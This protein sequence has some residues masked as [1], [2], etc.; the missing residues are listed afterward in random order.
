MKTDARVERNRAA[1]LQGAQEVLKEEGWEALT[2]ERVA[3]RSGVGRSTVYRHWPDRTALLMDA[4]DAIGAAMHQ[5]ATGDL[6]T[7]LVGELERFRTMISQPAEGR[8]LATLAYHWCTDADVGRFKERL[9]ARHTSLIQEAISR[10]MRSG[11]I[12]AGTDPNEAVAALMGPLC[13]RFFLSGEPVTPDFAE[14]VVDRF[15]DQHAVHRP[16]RLTKVRPARQ[17]LHG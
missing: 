12:L 15:L 14:R 2:Q 5:E 3:T 13:Y 7:D 6:R 10:S 8:L 11:E 17:L 16:E 1:I 4:L 9:T